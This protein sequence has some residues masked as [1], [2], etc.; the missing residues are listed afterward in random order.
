MVV[1]RRLGCGFSVASYFQGLV[2]GLGV[3]IVF[4]EAGAPW[5]LRPL[6][7]RLKA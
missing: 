1:L 2:S 3:F 6:D 7:L 5:Q 4:E